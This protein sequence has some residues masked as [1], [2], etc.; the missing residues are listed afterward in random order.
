MM[1]VAIVN[2]ECDN[3]LGRCFRDDMDRLDLAA[4][5]NYICR[6]AE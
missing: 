3:F 6:Y 2:Y 1:P 5:F 4:I